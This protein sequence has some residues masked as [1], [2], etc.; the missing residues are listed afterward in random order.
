[1]VQFHE[2]MVSRG[3]LPL[4]QPWG[5]I[6]EEGVRLFYANAFNLN[7]NTYTFHTYVYGSP[8]H[9][10]SDLILHVLGVPCALEHAIPFF[11][12]SDPR[13]AKGNDSSNMIQES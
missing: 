9:I 5:I 6:Q 13:K 8:L 12:G 10:N 11:E 3:W 2:H 4:F 1:M 7:F